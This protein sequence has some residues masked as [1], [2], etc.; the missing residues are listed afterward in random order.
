MKLKNDKTFFV[1][2]RRVQV[3]FETVGALHVACDW[4]HGE[5]RGRG[6]GVDVRLNRAYCVLVLYG[7][8]GAGVA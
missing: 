8:P 4:I 3:M 5:G 7:V 2:A 1:V 6:A